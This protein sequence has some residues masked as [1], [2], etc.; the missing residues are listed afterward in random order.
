M[1]NLTP[2]PQNPITDNPQANAAW[3]GWFERLRLLINSA[4]ISVDWANILN[5]PT[6]I[7]GYGITNAYTK[8][9]VDNKALEISITQS[10]MHMGA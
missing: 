9:E 3:M 2:Y 1:A 8:T 6:T 10:F 7:A 5:T 4:I